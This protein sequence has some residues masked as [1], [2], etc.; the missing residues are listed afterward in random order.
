VAEGARLARETL[1]RLGLAAIPPIA[2]GHELGVQAQAPSAAA[3]AIVAEARRDDA[4]ALFVSCGG[5]LTNV[6]E[7][8][9]LAPDIAGRMTVIWIGGGG[10]PDGAWEYNLSADLAAAQH[11]IEETRVPLWQVPQPAYRQMQVSIAEMGADMRPISPFSE[12]LYERFTTPPAFVELGGTWPMGDSPPVLLTAISAESSRYRDLSARQI[13]AD[14]T[15]G[16]EVPGRTVRVFETVD[17]RLTWAD[18]LARL[19]LHSAP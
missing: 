10:Y 17:L 14:S 8:L 12:W 16:E 15:Y 13:S 6:A 4:M 2:G 18:F 3:L 5:P 9:R 11:V 7:A 1:R 19:R